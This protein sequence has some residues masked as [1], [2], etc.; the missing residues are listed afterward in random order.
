MRYS[1][2]VNSA[3]KSSKDAIKTGSRRAIQKT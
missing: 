1:K 3:K 2:L